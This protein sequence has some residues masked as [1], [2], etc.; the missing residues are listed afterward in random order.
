MFREMNPQERKE[1]DVRRRQARLSQLEGL[2]D[3]AYEIIT[4]IRWTDDYLDS[5]EVKTPEAD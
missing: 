2:F 4:E 1:R 3:E 5:A